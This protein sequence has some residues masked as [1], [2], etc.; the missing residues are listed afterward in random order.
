M[1][2][3]PI[4]G[5]I[6]GSGLDRLDALKNAEQIDTPET[7]Y[8]QASDRITIGE[9]GS[10]TV[11]FLPRHGARHQFAPC[12][13]P[14]K[15]NLAALKRTGVKTVVATCIAG[16]LKSEIKPGD[17]VVPDQFVNR[18]WGRDAHSIEPDG[19][20]VHLPMAE[21]YCKRLRGACVAALISSSVPR[22]HGSGTT[23]VIQGPR[24]ST[25]AESREFIAQ[26]WDIVNMTQYPECLFARELGLCY[27]VFASITDWDVGTGLTCCMDATGME[28]VLKVFHANTAL[29]I[30][31]L[32][33]LIGSHLSTF[34]C[35]CAAGTITEYYKKR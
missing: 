35:D 33:N 13:V 17:F 23:V 30:Q 29:M 3:Q 28:E 2:R 1:K 14:Y 7:V 19:S 18:T 22:V 15:A 20:F 24:F 25:R 16:S 9:L 5:I 11:A 21:P 27:A 26:G 4:I 34:S 6:G 32:T 31:V 12:Q 10:Q 8:G